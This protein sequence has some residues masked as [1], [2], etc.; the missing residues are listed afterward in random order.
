MTLSLKE[1]GR[2][3]RALNIRTRNPSM[4][5]RTFVDPIDTVVATAVVAVLF[6][7]SPAAAQYVNNICG[8]GQG[9]CQVNPAQVGSECG[10]ATSSGIM[11]GQILPPGGYSIQPRMAVSNICRTYRGA[12]Q[13]YPLPLGSQCNCFG[14]PGFVSAK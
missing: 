8:W 6:L 13:T 7:A 10:C 12:C 11:Q 2:D 3:D 14:D 1:R 9:W 5:G 4:L